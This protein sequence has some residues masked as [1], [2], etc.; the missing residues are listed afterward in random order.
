MDK[1]KLTD[2]YR[3]YLEQ[4]LSPEE[5]TEFRMAVHQ[6][7]NETVFHELLD[8]RWDS[9]QENL[10]QD[11]PQ[12][13]DQRLFAQL[14]QRPVRR[15]LWPRI[16]AAASIL[17][18]FGA[19]YAIYHHKTKIA[20]EA[21]LAAKN[22]IEPGSN[23]AILKTGHGKTIYLAKV[24]NGILSKSNGFTIDKTGDGKVSY[25]SETNAAAESIFYDTLST[26]RK[27]TYQI[28]F[29]DGSTALLNAA[30]QIIF[31][32]RFAGNNRTIQLV[33]GEAYFEVVH[34]TQMPFRVIAQKE[35]IE[36]IGTH[37]NVSAYHDDPALKTTL[38]VGSVKVTANH[39]ELILKPGEQAALKADHLSVTDVDTDDVLAWKN[40]Y[41]QFGGETLESVMRKV[42]RWYDVD[43][44]YTNDALKRIPFH[45]TVS[46]YEKVS[47]VLKKLELTGNDVH[48]K[49]EN[50]Q[51]TVTN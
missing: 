14:D 27:G 11:L 46:K 2:L 21:Q 23:Q 48:F 24:S 7:E 32:E 28:R 41:F 8:D 3:K 40:G 22:D 15:R 42:A 35:I 12:G 25:N 9:L 6:P 13:A 37:F 19:G 47:Q 33:N 38:I 4:R 26:P 30:S 39:H 10:L 1:V 16:A 44:V 36:D 31:P 43:V 50:K 51:I 5:L 49:I 20:G 17:I 45:G 29:A 34:N 18:V